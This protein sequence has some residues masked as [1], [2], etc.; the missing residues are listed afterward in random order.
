MCVRRGRE[1]EGGPKHRVVVRRMML[2]CA[3][4]KLTIFLC[5]VLGRCCNSSPNWGLEQD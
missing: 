2:M 1:L 4:N 5:C 3:K